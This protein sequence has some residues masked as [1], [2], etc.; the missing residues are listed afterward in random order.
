MSNPLRAATV[1]PSVVAISAARGPDLPAYAVP[2]DRPALYQWVVGDQTTIDNVETIGHTGG[3]IGRWRRVAEYD[4]GADLTDA[5]QTIYVT[6]DHW[7]VMPAGT[8][9]TNRTITLGTTGAVRGS[10]IIVTRMDSS[11]NTLTVVNGGLAAGTLTT[12]PADY[13][14]YAKFKF[15]GTN[16]H[17]REFA[18]VITAEDDGNTDFVVGLGSN[19]GAAINVAMV[20]ATAAYVATGRQQTVRLLAGQ[21]SLETAVVFGSGV[22]LVGAGGGATH[23]VPAFTGSA[24]D[25]LNC[26]L[27]ARGSVSTSKLDTTLTTSAKSG[28]RRVSVGSVGIIAAGD[29]IVID[30]RNAPNDGTAAGDV[31]P[32][33]S[34]DNITLTEIAEVE[35]VA[36]PLVHLTSAIVQH[37]TPTNGGLGAACT[38]RGVT[39]VRNIEISGIAFSGVG[40]TI[41]VGVLCDY[42]SGVKIVDCTFEGFARTCVELRLGTRD[43]DVDVESLGE[44]NGLLTLHSAM[45]GCVRSLRSRSGGKRCHAAGTIGGLLWVDRRT[46]NVTFDDIHLS[47]ACRGIEGNGGVNL[48][49]GK[50]H[51]WDMD[52][53]E[54]FARPRLAQTPFS[55]VG[56]TWGHNELTE[57]EYALGIHIDSLY[58]GNCRHADTDQF[59]VFWHDIYD[60]SVGVCSIQNNGLS[61]EDTVDGAA[62]WMNGCVFQDCK[63][64][65]GALKIKGCHFALKHNSSQ[66]MRID[67][68]DVNPSSGN[69]P[70]GF[71]Y[72]IT[73]DQS[74][75][76]LLS[77][78]KLLATG[79]ILFGSNYAGDPIPVDELTHDS[80]VHQAR[81]CF[82]AKNKTG[83]Q[84]DQGRV[85]MLDGATAATYLGSPAVVTATADT[86]KAAVCA[87]AYGIAN[88]A[89]GFFTMSGGSVLC[90]AAVVSVGDRLET[91][92]ASH[93][94][95]SGTTAPF[96]RALSSKGAGVDFVRWTQ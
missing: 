34:G 33:S 76:C 25:P 53:R 24:T 30:G 4:R 40:Q 17:L 21:Y 96:G 47:H 65:V 13:V 88:N 80:A 7:R 75:T 2:L 32:L 29:W 87:H 85:A 83:A 54:L 92:G 52:S 11:A 90:S 8:L 59:S 46:S 23:V 6:G 16:W 45:E 78:G 57:V 94:A 70:T 10:E 5:N 56:F 95:E 43:F 77:I 3:T 38:V 89:W 12:L 9:S 39:P 64:Y 61:G 15:D 27:G 84:L 82:V 44:N 41:A 60:L 26:L 58:V 73:F 93:Q 31:G 91:T 66:F 55:G 51:I 28:H 18:P 69:D 72:A 62:M 42:V 68:L 63:G 48:H 37:H 71:G 50:I 81:S 22:R 79:G 36:A 35:S 67:L 49:F 19:R 86:P 74:T 14:S 1:Y 20:D